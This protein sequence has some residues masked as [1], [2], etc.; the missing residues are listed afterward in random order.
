MECMSYSSG[1]VVLMWVN[2]YYDSLIFQKFPVEHVLKHCGYN[3]EGSF[4]LWEWNWQDTDN[5]RLERVSN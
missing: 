5:G 2:H 1:S 4:E 3:K